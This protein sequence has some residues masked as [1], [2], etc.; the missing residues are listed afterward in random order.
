VSTPEKPS[1][2]SRKFR[3]PKSSVAASPL[4]AARS[5]SSSD[6]AV[7]V[8]LPYGYNPP[9]PPGSDG[10]VEDMVTHG[11]PDTVQGFHHLRRH[12]EEPEQGRVGAK[13][14][15]DHLAVQVSVKGV[16][17]IALRSGCLV[18]HLQMG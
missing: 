16:P 15:G 2:T 5:L 6:P 13:V 14:R 8:G 10:H 12:D 4:L 9:R 11:D 3:P 18:T 1:S 17:S 7:L